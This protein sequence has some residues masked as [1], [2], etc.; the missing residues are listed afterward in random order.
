MLRFLSRFSLLHQFA[1][2]AAIFALLS[3]LGGSVIWLKIEALQAIDREVI[4]H[5]FPSRLALGEAKVSAGTFASLAY[6]AQSADQDQLREIQACVLH[7]LG[8]GHLTLT[9]QARS[10]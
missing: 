3:G 4:E 9:D 10:T 5:S 1:L 8:L 2:L 6:R 7:A